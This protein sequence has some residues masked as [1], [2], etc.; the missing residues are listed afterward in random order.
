MG[1]RTKVLNLIYI[2]ALRQLCVFDGIKGFTQLFNLFLELLLLFRNFIIGR[3][4]VKLIGCLKFLLVRGL[5]L[6]DSR[7][8]GTG[9]KFVG[10]GQCNLS[11]KHGVDGNTYT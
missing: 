7:S 2:L 6:G 9:R 11:D 5:H 4:V 8:S 10:V 3:L 1:P